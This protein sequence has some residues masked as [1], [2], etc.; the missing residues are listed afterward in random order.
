MR[1]NTF[2]AIACIICAAS[3]WAWAKDLTT[4]TNPDGSLNVEARYTVRVGFSAYN[5]ELTSAVNAN[6]RGL[7]EYHSSGGNS[8]NWGRMNNGAT[9]L[10][11]DGNFTPNTFGGA[12]PD[13]AGYLFDCPVKNITMVKFWNRT[14]GDGGTFAA[15]PEVQY[16]DAPDP[17]GVWH[18]ISAVTW[19]PVYNPDYL[20][21]NEVRLY[22]IAV[23]EPLSNVWG[24]RLIGDG[25]PNGAVA[26]D[27][28]GWVGFQELAVFG[29]LD[30]GEIDLSKN[31]AL[32]QTAIATVEH[33]GTLA[34]LTDGDLTTRMDTWGPWAKEDYLGVQWPTPQYRVSAIGVAFK[35]F[36]DGGI[37]D[38]CQDPLRVEYTTVSNSSWTPVAGLNKFRY[39]YVWQRLSYLP[40]AQ[41]GFLFTFDEIDGLNG[42]RIIGDPHG[43]SGD[44][45]GFLGAFEVEVF[46]KP[47]IGVICDYDNDGD[48][49]A[50]DLALFIQ[51]AGGVNCV[52]GPTIPYDAA[53][54]TR[55]LD[56]DGDVDQMDFAVF[57]LCFSGS[58]VPLDPR[59]GQ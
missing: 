55:D 32:H 18:T 3:A 28:T 11:A 47:S 50:L 38:D 29:D 40:A 12:N 33:A 16:L 26:S 9:T 27:P 51:T 58:G 34:N 36:A 37:F 7:I 53:C 2:V 19:A 42:L 30:I 8:G 5:A 49:D 20:P 39:P 10:A 4:R 6:S 54:K 48:V 57:Q 24:I 44:K 23:N 25:N 31:L 45:D 35:Y 46:A 14:N 21:G 59:C 43:V 52:S 56:K 41:V 1:K 22:E 15:T 13:Y 17:I